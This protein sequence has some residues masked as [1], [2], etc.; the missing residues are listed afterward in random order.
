MAIKVYCIVV[1]FYDGRFFVRIPNTFREYSS[2]RCAVDDPGYVCFTRDHDGNYIVCESAK[3]NIDKLFNSKREAISSLTTYLEKLTNKKVK[4][5]HRF[6]C[7]GDS[8]Q[9]QIIFMDRTK[10]V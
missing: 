2:R 9:S 5:Y 1:L 3:P 8:K 4:V 7:V 10:P 6:A